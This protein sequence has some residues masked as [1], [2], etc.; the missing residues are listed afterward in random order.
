[1]KTVRL[2]FP[3]VALTLTAPQDVLETLKLF[4]PYSLEDAASV[5]ADLHY[6]VRHEPRGYVLAASHRSR[7]TV[8]SSLDLGARD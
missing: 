5:A 7:E 8:G 3:S 1:M 4:Y 2:A 6:D